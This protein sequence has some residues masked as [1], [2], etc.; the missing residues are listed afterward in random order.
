MYSEKPIEDSTG[1]VQPGGSND[2]NLES[3]SVT[4]R[5]DRRSS[6]EAAECLKPGTEVPG[7][8]GKE[9]KS[10]RDHTRT[11]A[12]SLGP[13]LAVTSPAVPQSTYSSARPK[14]QAAASRRRASRRGTS[15]D[16]TSDPTLSAPAREARGT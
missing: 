2:S 12:H 11:H 1:R 10:R 6:R 13:V 5:A 8:S 15:S 9:R 7:A 4:A 16:R 14:D 3:L